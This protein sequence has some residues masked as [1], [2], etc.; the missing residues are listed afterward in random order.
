MC[1]PFFQKLAARSLSR[2]QASSVANVHE[3]FF[4]ELQRVLPHVRKW[5]EGYIEGTQAA[6]GLCLECM[7]VVLTF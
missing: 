5:V 2:S 6:E 3:G 4:L 1:L 7:R